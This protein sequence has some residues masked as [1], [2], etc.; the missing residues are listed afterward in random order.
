MVQHSYLAE[1]LITAGRLDS[2]N[3]GGRSFKKIIGCE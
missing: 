2:F 1:D 3:P